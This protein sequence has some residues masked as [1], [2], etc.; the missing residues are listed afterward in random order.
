MAVKTSWTN[1]IRREGKMQQLSR[2][3]EDMS[4]KLFE[5]QMAKDELA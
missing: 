5:A 4:A 3:S 1:S 2:R